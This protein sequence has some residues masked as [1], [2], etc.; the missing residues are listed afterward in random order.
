VR[1]LHERPPAGGS[2]S[3]F[4]G[5]T[6]CFIA[7]KLYI[8]GAPGNPSLYALG[9]LRER[10]WRLWAARG[11]ENTTAPDT[12]GLS[13][14]AQR[15]PRRRKEKHH[16]LSTRME[17]IPVRMLIIRLNSRI[18]ASEKL[19]D[20]YTYWRGIFRTHRSPSVGFGNNSPPLSTGTELFQKRLIFG[21]KA[22][23]AARRGEK[24]G[25]NF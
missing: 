7:L 22:G 3:G 6:E 25:E 5:S 23:C 1:T 24:S 9:T 18:W 12:S 10:H 8:P 17:Y 19:C 14:K 4:G 13:A 20:P 11:E 16:L 2:F 21:W 15:T